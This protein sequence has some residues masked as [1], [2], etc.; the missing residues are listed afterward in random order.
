MKNIL[1]NVFGTFSIAILFAIMFSW[2]FADA[3]VTYDHSD[4]LGYFGSSPASWTID[5][6]AGAN[7][8]VCI[9]F[10][11][12][13]SNADVVTAVTVG[14]TSL[15]FQGGGFAT[16]DR[17]E[18]LWCGVGVPSGVSETVSVSFT[19]GYLRPVDAVYLGVGSIDNPGGNSSGAGTS[20]A[21]SGTLSAAGMVVSAGI[22]NLASGVFTAGVGTTL[23]IQSNQG[24]YLVDNG[25]VGSIGSVTLNVNGNALSWGSG[26]ASLE[27]VSG[28]GGGGTPLGGATSTID[29]TESNLSTAVFLYFFCFFGMIWL[30]RKR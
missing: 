18:S 26:I 23:R 28:G 17:Y 11:G 16:G 20:Y 15:S 8:A 29:Q 9:G 6:S 25:S 21:T 22:G 13:T 5:T 14:G 12:G 27:P 2:T 30:L 10:L 19:G 24:W 3:A 1:L 7:P 4:D